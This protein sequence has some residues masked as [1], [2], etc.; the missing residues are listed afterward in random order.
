MTWAWNP[1]PIL[2]VPGSLARSHGVDGVAES[3]VKSKKY[4]LPLVVLNPEFAG[5]LV[6]GYLVDG[7]MRPP[8]DATIFDVGLRGSAG[9]GR[10][11]VPR[12]E[13]LDTNG[14]LECRADG[15]VFERPHYYGVRERDLGRKCKCFSGHPEPHWSATAP[16]SS[17]YS[18]GQPLL[19]ACRTPA[20]AMQPCPWPRA[21]R[22]RDA[23]A[24][25]S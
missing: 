13:R 7:R 17:P 11:H 6:I 25:R 10:Q 19:P 24:Q 12:P 16:N 5:A 1:T 3:L 23:E 21:R 4:L 15:E 2:Q 8:K 18:R 9:E 22:H 14:D 20:P